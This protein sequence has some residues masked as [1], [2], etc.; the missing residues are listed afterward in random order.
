MFSL[1]I[2]EVPVEGLDHQDLVPISSDQSSRAGALNEEPFV[3]GLVEEWRKQ[4]LRHHMHQCC[5]HRIFLWVVHLRSLLEFAKGKY[6]ET[7]DVIIVSHNPHIYVECNFLFIIF[8]HVKH[9]HTVS[10]LPYTAEQRV[11]SA[12]TLLFINIDI[13]LSYH[14]A[15][16]E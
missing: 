8:L 13:I 1:Y 12:I 2:F 5:C 9:F 6:D 14:Y 7:T 4:V 16:P 3:D 10:L 15:K 11:K